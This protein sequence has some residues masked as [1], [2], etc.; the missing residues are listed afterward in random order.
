MILRAQKAAEEFIPGGTTLNNVN[1][2]AVK[3]FGEDFEINGNF[4]YE[5]RKAP[6]YLPGGQNAT[7]ATIQLTWYP[8]RN[9]NF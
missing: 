7:N 2:Q 5:R 4:T 6:I 8:H 9:V 3:R 1:V